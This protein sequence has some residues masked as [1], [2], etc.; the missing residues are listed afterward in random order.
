MKA[1]KTKKVIS[2]KK[3]APLILSTKEMLKL[4][5]KLLGDN[6]NPEIKKH[7]PDTYWKV[8]V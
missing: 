1:K 3:K 4:S 8:K 6:F 7:L 2:R 5:E